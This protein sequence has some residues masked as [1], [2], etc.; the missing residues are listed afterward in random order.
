MLLQ[1]YIALIKHDIEAFKNYALGAK[2]LAK[3]T[4]KNFTIQI[5]EDDEIK[6]YAN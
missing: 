4:I 5:K 2:N 1:D 6:S 3:S